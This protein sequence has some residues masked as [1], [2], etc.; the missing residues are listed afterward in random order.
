LAAPKDS[1]VDVD[2][3]RAWNKEIADQYC[4]AIENSRFAGELLA[5]SLETSIQDKP[6]PDNGVGIAL[7]R[8]RAGEQRRQRENQELD[9]GRLTAGW[10]DGWKR[11]RR[12]EW[13]DFHG[14]KLPGLVER[15]RSTETDWFL[16]SNK[17]KLRKISFSR[18]SAGFFST[19]SLVAVQPPKETVEKIPYH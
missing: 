17:I 12:D 10:M 4:R 11:N 16:F 8:D 7:R 9:S 5:I 13:R 6:V 18:R 15:T 19:Q 14:D 2:R 3:G 1:A